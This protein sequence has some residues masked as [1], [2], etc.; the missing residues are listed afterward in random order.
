MLRRL[1]TAAYFVMLASHPAAALDTL[2][3]QLK[4]K[5][6]FNSP[7]YG[8]ASYSAKVVDGKFLVAV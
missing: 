1:T 7:G 5:H 2:S 8:V 3:L 4:W 6:Q